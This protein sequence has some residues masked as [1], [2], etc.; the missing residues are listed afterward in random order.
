MSNDYDDNKNEQINKDKYYCKYCDKHLDRKFN[1]DRHVLT[2]KHLKFKNDYKVIINESGKKVFVKNENFECKCGK[3]YKHQTNLIR[4]KKT[5]CILKNVNDNLQIKNISEKN[6]ENI[7]NYKE[8]ILTLI[9][10]NIKLK[11]K[12]SETIEMIYNN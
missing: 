6:K 7:A 1:F 12:L 11:N 5:N 2:A 9:N 3:I 4:H 8:I 10:E